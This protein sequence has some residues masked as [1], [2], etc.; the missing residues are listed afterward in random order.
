VFGLALDKDASFISHQRVVS[1]PLT[2]R[3]SARRETR[4]TLCQ[5]V[6]MFVAVLFVAVLSWNV[7]ILLFYLVKPLNQLSLNF[8]RTITPQRCHLAR[9]NSYQSTYGVPVNQ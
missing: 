9:K 4:A 5:F 1:V 6:V 3:D 7:V 8:T 2:S